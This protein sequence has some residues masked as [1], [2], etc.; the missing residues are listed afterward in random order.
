[1]TDIG[2]RM[3]ADLFPAAYTPHVP[4]K[5]PGNGDASRFGGKTRGQSKHLSTR[6]RM[7]LTLE[8]RGKTQGEIAQQMQMRPS[9]VHRIVNTDRYVAAREELL[10]RMDS[11][12]ATFK[13][14]AFTAL[15]NGLRSRDENVALRAS[16][17]W[18]R[19]AGFG[20]YGRG[21]AQQGVTAE[22][23][24]RQLLQVNVNVN[25]DK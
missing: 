23:V 10:G 5:I 25:V 22:D 12:F 9:S 20:Q 14:L 24:V 17:Q 7:I 15:G 6:V 11:E 16:E 21:N 3:L 19:A 2:S 4:A 1:M 13:S 18:M 8:L